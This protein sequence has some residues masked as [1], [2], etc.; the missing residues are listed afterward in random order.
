M[1][2]RSDFLPGYAVQRIVDKNTSVT[3]AG[4]L[5]LMALSLPSFEAYYIA[6]LFVTKIALHRFKFVAGE[7]PRI[8]NI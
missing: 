4:I 5:C 1:S 8:L 6:A 2:L 7:L 3:Q